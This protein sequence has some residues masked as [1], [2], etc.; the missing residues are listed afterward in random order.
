MK[1]KILFILSLLISYTIFSQNTIDLDKILSQLHL[2]KQQCATGMIVSKKLPYSQNETVVVIPEIVKEDEMEAEYNGHILIVDNNT[3]KIK[4]K[5]FQSSYWTSNA[6]IFST[7]TIDTAPYILSKNQRAFAIR[8]S[9]YTQSKPNPYST[10]TLTLFLKKDQKITPILDQF[11][12]KEYV[13]EWDMQCDGWSINEEQF[14]IVSKNKTN[15][16]FD[17]V[18]NTKITNRKTTTDDSDE[19]VDDEKT[20]YQKSTLKFNGTVYKQQSN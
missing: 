7:I 14:L 5:Y 10:E 20:S 11:T 13:G 18:I 12:S 15:D 3:N 1:T 2:T 6:L 8:S 17:I 4:Y 16:F 9:F 19:C